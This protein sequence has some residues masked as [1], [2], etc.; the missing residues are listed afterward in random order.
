MNKK[1]ENLPKNFIFILLL[2]SILC[3]LTYGYAIGRSDGPHIKS[4]FG[5]SIIFY[6]SLLIYFL[7]NFL[8]Q[9]INLFRSIKTNFLSYF[10]YDNY[11]YFF[12]KFKFSQYI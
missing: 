12:S 10:F 7:L 5:Y 6:C 2:I 8:N 9:K 3:F 11:G 1:N 4:T